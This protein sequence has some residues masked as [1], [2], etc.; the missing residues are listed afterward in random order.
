MRFSNSEL[1]D[2]FAKSEKEHMEINLTFKIRMKGNV[3]L[4]S[5]G[6]INLKSFDN[7]KLELL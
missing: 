4:V 3:H 6:L 5:P 1:N 2:D 7:L